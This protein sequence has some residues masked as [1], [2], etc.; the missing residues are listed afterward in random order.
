VGLYSPLLQ[1]LFF[2]FRVPYFQGECLMIG[3]LLGVVPEID[4][5]SATAALALLIGS[6]LMLR[7]RF[8][9]RR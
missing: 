5:A 7:D 8:L 6:T 3:V 4:P 2:G 1:Q 9:P